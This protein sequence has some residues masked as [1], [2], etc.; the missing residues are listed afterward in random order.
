MIQK[1]DVYKPVRLYRSQSLISLMQKFLQLHDVLKKPID[2]EHML[3][4]IS[5][6]VGCLINS[7]QEKA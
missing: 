1:Y 6:Q 7:I 4:S 3:R 2:L 5:S